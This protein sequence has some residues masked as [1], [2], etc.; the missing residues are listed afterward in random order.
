M[1]KDKAFTLI[2]LIAVL[3]IL[4]ILALIVTPLVLSIIR[5]AKIAADKRSVDNYG[6]SVE[7]AIASYIL[8]NSKLPNCETDL[9]IE[10]SGNQINCDVMYINEN[11]SIY[12]SQCRIGRREVLDSTTSDGYYHY[13]HLQTRIEEE[14]SQVYNSYQIGDVVT[15]NDIE[16]YVIKNSTESE[17]ALTLLKKE[18][19]TVEEVNVIL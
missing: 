9:T 1:K 8:D 7:L 3:V 10:Y 4:A 2:E 6:K 13:G 17:Q 14:P 15:Y 5:K 18:P 11:G 19:L 16:F 12:L